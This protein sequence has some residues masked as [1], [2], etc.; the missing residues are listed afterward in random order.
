MVELNLVPCESLESLAARLNS[1]LMNG[2]ALQFHN[3]GGVF[4]KEPGKKLINE[5]RYSDF[6]P[7]RGT[8]EELRKKEY[9]GI[10]FRKVLEW[11]ENFLRAGMLTDLFEK[12]FI[13]I[14]TQIKPSDPIL[15]FGPQSDP[16]NIRRTRFI[17]REFDSPKYGPISGILKPREFQ[18]LFEIKKIDRI[19]WKR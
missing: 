14:F 18:G 6:Y 7:L 2:R 4:A 12:N 11:E 10:V 16:L 1:D 3:N 17:S 8:P 9:Y 5:F 13:E 19:Y 15:V